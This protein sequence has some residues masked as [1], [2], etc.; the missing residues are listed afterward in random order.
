[1]LLGCHLSIAGGVDRAL[2][3]AREYGFASLAMFVRNQRQWSARALEAKTVRAFRRKRRTLGIGPIVAHGSY[4]VN[5]AARGPIR[6]RSIAATAEE[7]DRCRRL[8]IDYYVLHPGSCADRR[9][10]IRRIAEALNQLVAASADPGP[11]ILLET[12][13]GAGHT[14][15]GAFEDLAAI[16]DLLTPPERFGVCL[17]TC[18]VFAA[19][20]DLRTRCTYHQT[21]SRLHRVIG[22]DR[23]KAVHLNDCRS[24]L[25][26]RLDRHA[27]IGRGKIGREGFA[28]FV[29]DRRLAAVPGILETPKGFDKRARSWDLVNAAVL[30]SLIRKPPRG[31]TRRIG[32][33]CQSLPLPKHTSAA[34]R[35]AA[36]APAG[37]AVRRLLPYRRPHDPGHVHANR[38]CDVHQRGGAGVAPGPGGWDHRGPRPDAAAGG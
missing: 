20:Y 21:M 5:L 24:T 36:A 19:G 6:Q 26:S 1:M 27:H 18:H 31:A 37:L 17:D 4:L 14:I 22:L 33:R 23:L 2:E 32:D 10:G 9:V 28:C 8:G 13:S 12:T 15:G 38:V 11:V 16:L 34:S 7:L 29:N 35:K 3:Q 30:R 25:G